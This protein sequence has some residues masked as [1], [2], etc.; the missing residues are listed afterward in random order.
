MFMFRKKWYEKKVTKWTGR[1]LFAG[2]TFMT[3]VLTTLCSLPL[4]GMFVKEKYFD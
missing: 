4:V 3:V 1:D 2:T